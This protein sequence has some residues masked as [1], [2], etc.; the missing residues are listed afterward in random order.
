MNH[1]RRNNVLTKSEYKVYIIQV[2]IYKTYNIYNVYKKYKIYTSI[3][4]RLYLSNQDAVGCVIK[5]KNFFLKRG[6][7]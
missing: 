5:H 1:M 2:K 6:R 7:S 3:Y 4:L